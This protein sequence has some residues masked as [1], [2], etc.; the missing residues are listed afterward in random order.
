MLLLIV[1]VIFR[2]N[3]I[4]MKLLVLFF[5][6]LN[7]ISVYCQ[8]ECFKDCS[9]VMA[10][11][12]P[13]TDKLKILHGC[14]TP[15]FATKNIEGETLSSTE[16]KGKILVINFWYIGCAPCRA[17]IPGLNMLAEKYKKDVL[18]LSFAKD[19]IASLKKFV[20]KSPLYFQL[21]PSADKYAN[22][23]CIVAGYPTNMVVDK[24]GKVALMFSGGRVDDKASEEVVNRIEPTLIKLLSK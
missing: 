20:Q 16:L 6:T 2:V 21:I 15:E 19:D 12:L 9:K 4:P 8:S 23:F 10:S 24:E 13:F 7:S 1:K 22:L 17:E 18:F 3:Q 11:K 14:S 5:I